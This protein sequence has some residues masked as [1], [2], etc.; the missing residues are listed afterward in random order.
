MGVNPDDGFSE[1]F[2]VVQIGELTSLLKAEHFGIFVVSEFTNIKQ[3]AGAYHLYVARGTCACEENANLLGEIH[4]ILSL[5][6]P[7]Q[8]M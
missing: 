4:T 3:E 2:T 8:Y 5:I 6:H 1:V 7:I